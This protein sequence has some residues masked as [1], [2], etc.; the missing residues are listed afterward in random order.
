MLKF[1][2]LIYRLT[3]WYSPW[4]RVAEY[5]AFKKWLYSEDSFL[6]IAQLGSDAYG[7]FIGSWQADNGFYRKYNFKRF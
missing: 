6:T 2:A 4:A 7:T 1:W 3:G 5:R